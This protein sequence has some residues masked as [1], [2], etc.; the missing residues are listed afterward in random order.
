MRRFLLH[1]AI[2]AGIA[3]VCGALVVGFGL[4]DVSARKGHLPGVSWVLHTAFRNAVELRA[5][6]AEAVPDLSDPDLVALGARHYDGACRVCHAAPGE[7]RTATVRAMLP[8]PPPI[9]EAVADWEPQH[10]FA[11]VKHGVKMSGMPAWPTDRRDD[12]VWPVVA[13]LTRVPDMTLAQY[14]DLVAAPER[15]E[16]GDDTTVAYCASCH[17]ADG[18]GRDNA[19]IPRLDLLSEAY[20]A[21]TLAAYRSGARESGIMRHAAS[22]L[23]D[24]DDA[25]LARLFARQDGETA[26]QPAPAVDA[27]LVARG[28]S[29]ATGASPASTKVPACAACHGPWPQRLSA[30]F[31]RLSGQ[32][33]PYLRRQLELWRAEER[34][35]TARA[36]LMHEA[37]RA[38]EDADIRALAAF[39]AAQPPE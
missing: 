37:A 15:T 6:S 26:P 9:R 5:P 18:R 33:E 4:F 21:A 1:T 27:D 25:R 3:G 8:A 29:L 22:T 28:R 12:D 11:I 17:G 36:P 20:I 10:L 31:P 2:L 7:A 23:D 30:D 35:G 14:E 24:T 16:Q 13:F 38:L 34:G 19:H 39:Y 32:P